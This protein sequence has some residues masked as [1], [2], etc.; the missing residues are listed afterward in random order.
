MSL[1][2]YTSHIKARVRKN[3]TQHTTH[4]T[5]HTT[6]NTQHTTHNTQHTTHNTQHN[7]QNT[8]HNTQHTTHTTNNRTGVACCLPT[9]AQGSS[10]SATELVEKGAAR[11][12]LVLLVVLLILGVLALLIYLLVCVGPE[13]RRSASR[14][15]HALRAEFGEGTVLVVL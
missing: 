12:L 14:W 8:K 11:R 5:Q 2:T 10:V 3:N 13:L 1:W 6:H 15:R 7:T 9:C 4:N